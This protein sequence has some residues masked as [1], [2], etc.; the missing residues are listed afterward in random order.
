MSN[1]HL[2]FFKVAPDAVIPQY[3]SV[4]AAGMDL[5]VHTPGGHPLWLYPGDVRLLDTGLIVQITPG[6]ELQ[7]RPRSGL[8]LRFPSYLANSPGTID[9]D[10]RGEIKLL[11]VNHHDENRMIIAN[12][13]R[14][15]QAVLAPVIRANIAEVLYAD[16]S[17]TGRGAGGM[18]ST[19]GAAAVNP[20]PA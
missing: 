19:G 4:A 6:Y 8:S 15:A 3:Q 2:L 12:H 16:L 13:D 7:L 14:I 5:H 11:I 20:K 17:S 10:Y 1:I 9:S 18:G